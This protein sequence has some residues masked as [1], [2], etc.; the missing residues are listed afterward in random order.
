MPLQFKDLGLC[1]AEGRSIIHMRSDDVPSDVAE[2]EYLLTH[3]A[4][5]NRLSRQY[6]VV[7]AD[8]SVWL[9]EKVHLKPR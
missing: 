5:I 4:R 9:L 3:W 1:E 6:E 2:L 7:P 8:H